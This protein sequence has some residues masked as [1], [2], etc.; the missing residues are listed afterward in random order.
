MNLRMRALSLELGEG[1]TIAPPWTDAKLQETHGAYVTH[2]ASG[3]QLHVRG[4]LLAG[5]AAMLL[6]HL[7]AQQWGMPPLD[8]ITRRIGSIHMVAGTFTMRGKKPG[9]DRV[10]EWFMSDGL[11]GANAALPHSRD[12]APDLLEACDRVMDTL[13]LEAHD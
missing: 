8:V 12:T 3:L 7:R 1:W 13:K 6:D 9:F 2:V 11:R 4:Y 5:D 10:R